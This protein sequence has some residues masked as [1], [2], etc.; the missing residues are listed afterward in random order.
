MLSVSIRSA[1]VAGVREVALSVPRVVGRA[2]V[3][4]DLM[5]DLDTDEAEA[6][7][8]RARLVKEAASAVDP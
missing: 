8:A 1:E 3:V 7:A 5:P 4:A 6:L 2:G